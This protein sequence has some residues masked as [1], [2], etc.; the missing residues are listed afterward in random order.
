MLINFE[1]ITEDLTEVEL[2]YSGTIKQI[3]LGI[4][5]DENPI[6]QPLLCEIINANLIRLEGNPE[7]NITG[8][9]LRKFVNFYRTNGILPIIA[10]SEGYL[11]TNN[12]E[13][14]QS[15]IKSLEQRAASILKAA[16]GLRKFI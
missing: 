2:S 5:D 13:V 10:T 11:I 12:K 7:I 8:V 14:I 3:L 4:L 16:S 9:R 15:Q 1:E 6:K